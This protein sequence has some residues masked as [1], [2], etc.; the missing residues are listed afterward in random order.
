MNIELLRQPRF[1]ISIGVAIAIAGAIAVIAVPGH[2]SGP[3]PSAFF[4]KCVEP[5]SG[6]EGEALADVEH[7]CHVR[8][9]HS[10]GMTPAKMRAEEEALH[11]S[12][13]ARFAAAAAQEAAE[14]Q[15]E[16]I[17]GLQQGP[18]GPPGTSQVFTST[19]Q[20]IGEVNGQ[21]Y[22]VY[23]GAKATPGSGETVRSELLIYL[24]PKN[25]NTTEREHQIGTA[26]PPEGGTLPLKITAASGSVLTIETGTGSTLK[27]N[28][29][30]QAF[31]S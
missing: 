30:A 2:A 20:W 21:W 5:Y 18:G 3:A 16:R 29:A 22:Q 11:A 28:V 26:I 15:P 13:T 14:P 12:R 24:G 8:E 23:A 10:R 9:E 4:L 19:G 31:E 27:F 6:H 7:E 25:I 1:W 17:T